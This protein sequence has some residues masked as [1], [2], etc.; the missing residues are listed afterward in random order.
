MTNLFTT[1]IVQRVN[2]RHLFLFKGGSCCLVCR[3]HINSEKT[4]ENEGFPLMT[5]TRSGKLPFSIARVFVRFY[6]STN[7][8]KYGRGENCIYEGKTMN[9]RLHVSVVLK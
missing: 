7:Q 3:P 1:S 9:T 4:I 6:D 5:T 8:Q 2:F